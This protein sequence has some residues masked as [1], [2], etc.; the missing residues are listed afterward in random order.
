MLRVSQKVTP[1]TLQLGLDNQ[2]VNQKLTFCYVTDSQLSI[3]ITISSLLIFNNRWYFVILGIFTFSN[4]SLRRVQ[5]S[6]VYHR[7]PWHRRVRNR[8]SRS[9]LLDTERLPTSPTCHAALPR[10]LHSRRRPCLPREAIS[11]SFLPQKKK[12]KK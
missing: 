3:L 10:L 2:W 11:L 9:G 4:P 1:L 12:K 5:V 7:G 8:R 6:P